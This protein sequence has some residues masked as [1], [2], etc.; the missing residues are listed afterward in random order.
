MTVLIQE[1]RE[2]IKSHIGFERFSDRNIKIIKIPKGYTANAINPKIIL[3]QFTYYSVKNNPFDPLLPILSK[4]QKEDPQ[5]KQLLEQ[6]QAELAKELAEIKEIEK[7]QIKEVVQ[8]LLTNEQTREASRTLLRLNQTCADFLDEFNRVL[9]PQRTGRS[10]IDNEINIAIEEFLSERDDGT[11]AGVQLFA[12]QIGQLIHGLDAYAKLNPNMFDH[13]NH[14]L[15]IVEET[16]KNL[17]EKIRTAKGIKAAQL[18]NELVTCCDIVLT[19]NKYFEEP[20]TKEP[21]L[22]ASNDIKEEQ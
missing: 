21:T 10:H 20:E 3:E 16:Y 17:I 14:D 22:E 15:Q 1:K 7:E 5:F 12:E 4:I 19:G 11:P 9:R 13:K 2:E 6:K 8:P 18:C